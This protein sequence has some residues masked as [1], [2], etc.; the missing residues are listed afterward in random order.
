MP[1]SWSAPAR[2][3]SQTTAHP[4]AASCPARC[5]ASRVLPCPPAACSRCAPNPGR[6]A[7]ACRSRRMG[8]RPWKGT[9]CR[10]ARSSAA[11]EAPCVAV[12]GSAGSVSCWYSMGSRTA[13]VCPVCSAS[14]ARKPGSA[15]ST[16]AGTAS[17]RECPSHAGSE[18]ITPASRSPQNNAAPDM[19]PHGEPSRSLGGWPSTFITYRSPTYRSP[20]FSVPE[21]CPSSAGRSSRWASAGSP[22]LSHRIPG[23]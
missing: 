11:G 17:S 22:Q 7:Q 1:A 8:S 3:S 6:P 12:M 5:K 14:T 2:A 19:P 13:P 15:S 20:G 21:G 10:R 9:T 16:Y 18:A 23:R 4:A